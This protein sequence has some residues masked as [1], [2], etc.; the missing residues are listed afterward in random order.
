MEQKKNFPIPLQCLYVFCL[1]KS[2]QYTLMP[3]F[4]PHELIW[5]IIVYVSGFN[6]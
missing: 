5:F 1:S 6:I 3:L 4:E 2:A